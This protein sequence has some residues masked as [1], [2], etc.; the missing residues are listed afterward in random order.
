MV[1]VYLNLNNNIT[2]NNI[3]PSAAMQALNASAERCPVA[4]V[5]KTRLGASE[6]Q[7]KILAKR[8]GAEISYP[9]PVI[10]PVPEFLLF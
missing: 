1:A 2:P 7:Q 8:G 5:I 3:T 9:L 6:R 10:L 4:F